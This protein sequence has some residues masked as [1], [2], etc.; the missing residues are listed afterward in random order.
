MKERGGGVV[1]F[2]LDRGNWDPKGSKVE[3]K[4]MGASKKMGRERVNS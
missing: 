3:K 4:T 1:I 2:L